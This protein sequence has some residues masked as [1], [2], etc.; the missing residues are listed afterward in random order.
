[1]PA[2][3][4]DM[5][6]QDTMVASCSDAHGEGS[7]SSSVAGTALPQVH[8]RVI[9]YYKKKRGGMISGTDKFEFGDM[10]CPTWA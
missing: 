1:M 3:R 10:L 5:A 8:D 4:R 6:I 7:S 2:M 9:E